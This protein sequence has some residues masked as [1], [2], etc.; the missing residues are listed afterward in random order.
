MLRKQIDLTESE[1]QSLRNLAQRTGRSRGELSREAIDKLL[2]G[3]QEPDQLTLLRQA[4][5]LWQDRQ[6]LPNFAAL[7]QE[8]DR[9]GADS[10]CCPCKKI[11]H[12]IA[13]LAN[14]VSFSWTSK[15]TIS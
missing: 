4:C 11:A 15:S 7:R 2:A 1:R 8:W 5:R 14:V 10:E 13:A 6:D 12:C 9:F 3:C